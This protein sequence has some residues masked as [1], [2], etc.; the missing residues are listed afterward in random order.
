MEAGPCA[1]ASRFYATLVETALVAH[2]ALTALPVGTTSGVS[3][4]TA[5]IRQI[6][7]NLV[8]LSSPEKFTLGLDLRARQ[9]I[10][11]SVFLSGDIYGIPGD[12]AAS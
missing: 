6:T 11:E 12:Q 10:A 4:E 2:R 8:I 3:L 7:H 5:P 1:A 9:E